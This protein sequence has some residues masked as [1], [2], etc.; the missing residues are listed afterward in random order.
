MIRDCLHRSSTAPEKLQECLLFPFH[1]EFSLFQ[2]VQGFGR[3]LSLEGSED[4]VGAKR[5]DLTHRPVSMID[6]PK[7]GTSRGGCAI[8]KIVARESC[9]KKFVKEKKMG[10]L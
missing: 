10:V 8:G 4:S 3:V 1:A 9:K 2:A 7:E 5:S 6:I